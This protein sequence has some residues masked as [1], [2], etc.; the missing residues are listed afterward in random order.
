VTA[1][2]A[3]APAGGLPAILGLACRLN[4]TGRIERCTGVVKLTIL[5]R[6]SDPE[7]VA[8]AD[9]EGETFMNLVHHYL[10]SI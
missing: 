7:R 4:R 9:G 3:G 1:V 10:A 8:S 5:T 6:A 2:Q